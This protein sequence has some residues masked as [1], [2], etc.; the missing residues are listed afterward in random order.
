MIA[1]AS[2]IVAVKLVASTANLPFIRA[3]QGGRKPPYPYISYYLLNQTQEKDENSIEFRRYNEPQ[4]NIIKTNLKK[5]EAIIS[6]SFIGEDSKD[7]WEPASQSFSF[8]NSDNGREEIEESSFLYPKLISDNVQDRSA[9]LETGW[10]IKLG[11]DIMLIR[12]AKNIKQIETIEK[13][14]I[15]EVENVH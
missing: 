9:Y 6:L 14:E 11:F 13:V 12:Y 10:E 1:L 2:I 5:E 15:K 3:Y 8:V 4:D 7:I